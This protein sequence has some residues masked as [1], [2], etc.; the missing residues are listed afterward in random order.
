MHSASYLRRGW[1]RQTLQLLGIVD[2]LQRLQVRCLHANER[3]S[4][5]ACR[6][7]SSQS[8]GDLCWECCKLCVCTFFASRTC[9]ASGSEGLPN[10][11]CNPEPLDSVSRF[12]MSSDN[13]ES[14]RSRTP[15]VSDVGPGSWR[16]RARKLTKARLT[17]F[18]AHR[19]DACPPCPSPSRTGPRWNA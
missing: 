7:S 4:H 16:R 3:G 13:A 11:S 18:Q 1:R 15:L 8:V 5:V 6:T 12:P 9:R 2:V 17:P 19:T 14:S 10:E